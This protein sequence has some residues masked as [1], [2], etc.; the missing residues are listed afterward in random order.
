[1]SLTIWYYYFSGVM[2]EPRF[3]LVPKGGWGD[4]Q[5]GSRGIGAAIDAYH[6]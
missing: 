1:M 4:A 3:D 2:L 5:L 6:S